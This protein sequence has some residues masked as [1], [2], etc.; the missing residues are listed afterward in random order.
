VRRILRANNHPAVPAIFL[1]IQSILPVEDPALTYCEKLLSGSNHRFGR[2]PI[3][4]CWSGQRFSPV[5]R[6]VQENLGKRPRPASLEVPDHLLFDG[7]FL[8]GYIFFGIALT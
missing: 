1:D 4:W 6:A 3:S 5:I 8:P 2:I 7:F